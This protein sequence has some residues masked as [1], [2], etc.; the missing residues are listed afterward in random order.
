ML[1]VYKS[2]S[3]G[4]WLFFYFA[5]GFAVIALLRYAY[6]MLFRR[7]TVHLFYFSG[8]DSQQRNMKVYVVYRV[9]ALTVF[10]F[11]FSLLSSVYFSPRYLSSEFSTEIMFWVFSGISVYM[12][13]RYIVDVFLSWLFDVRGFGALIMEKNIALR[14]AMGVYG[15]SVFFLLYY[16]GALD[17]CGAGNMLLYVFVLYITLSFAVA[18]EYLVSGPGYFLYFIFYLCIVEICPLLIAWSM[19]RQVL[20]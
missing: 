17:V 12:V 6:P 9:L 20:T 13:V 15:L 16:S 1:E 14:L 2:S 7:D 3:E 4:S 19:F 10:A 8:L 5:A 11:T 18:A